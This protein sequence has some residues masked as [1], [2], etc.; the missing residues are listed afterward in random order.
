MNAGLIDSFIQDLLL[1]VLPLEQ[2]VLSN[3]S[4]SQ[5]T[6]LG[7]SVWYELEGSSGLDFQC[8]QCK[9]EV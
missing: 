3:N 4:V 8:N 7:C 1:S 5:A 2:E 6:T 9:R